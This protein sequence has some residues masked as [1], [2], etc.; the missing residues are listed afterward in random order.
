MYIEAHTGSW[1]CRTP[2]STNHAKD[3]H[4]HLLPAAPFKHEI[5]GKR[6][7]TGTE[8]EQPCL[9]RTTSTISSFSYKFHCNKYTSKLY[10]ISCHTVT[11]YLRDCE[12]CLRNMAKV[13]RNSRAL[14]KI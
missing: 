10:N 6:L 1:L 3:L 4:T 12:A 7:S 2:H 11:L 9:R 13:R 8:D 14:A 5:Y